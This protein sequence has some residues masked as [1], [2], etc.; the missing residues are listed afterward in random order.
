MFGL[1]FGI[2]K[3]PPGVAQVANKTYKSPGRC[4]GK[5][6]R[7]SRWWGETAAPMDVLRTQRTDPPAHVQVEELEALDMKEGQPKR[8]YIDIL[9]YP[10]LL[11]QN[12]LSS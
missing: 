8:L 3:L 6:V 10:G 9:S 12:R 1:Y 2:R 4:N 11:W 7:E 5:I